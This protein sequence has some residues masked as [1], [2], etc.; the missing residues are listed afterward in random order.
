MCISNRSCLPPFRYRH[1]RPLDSRSYPKALELVASKRVD[2]KPLVSHRFSLEQAEE[3]FQMALTGKGNPI[4]I[5]I[6]F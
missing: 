4:K 2:L 3:A 6:N 5:A 1:L